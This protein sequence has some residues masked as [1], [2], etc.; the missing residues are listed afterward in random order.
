MQNPDL[1]S[2][3]K[4]NIPSKFPISMDNAKTIYN[5]VGRKISLF[6]S[7]MMNFLFPLSYLMSHRLTDNWMNSDKQTAVLK[8]NRQ[9]ISNIFIAKRN[10]FFIDN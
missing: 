3:N 5:R 2:S 10:N 4:K 1:F 7:K 8:K 9:L 6:T